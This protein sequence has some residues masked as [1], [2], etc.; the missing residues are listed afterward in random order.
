MSIDWVLAKKL[1]EIQSCTP[2]QDNRNAKYWY[3][4]EISSRIDW[5]WDADCSGTSPTLTRLIVTE[6][7]WHKVLRW[8]YRTGGLYGLEEHDTLCLLLHLYNTM[9]ITISNEESNITQKYPCHGAALKAARPLW[10]YMV[11]FA[12]PRGDGILRQY[13]CLY[14]AGVVTMPCQARQTKEEEEV[15]VV[16]GQT[17][18]SSGRHRTLASVCCNTHPFPWQCRWTCCIWIRSFF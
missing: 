9:W 8:W 12:P 13:C 10:N 15:V 17:P 18:L 1:P 6:I 16:V 14:D 4:R 11:I 3:L 2:P 5:Y 7:S